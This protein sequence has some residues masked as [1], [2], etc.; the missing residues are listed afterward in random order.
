MCYTHGYA[1][2]RI[3]K[4]QRVIINAVKHSLFAHSLISA[5]EEGGTALPPA[6]LS[7]KFVLERLLLVV[8]CQVLLCMSISALQDC[9]TSTFNLLKKAALNLEKKPLF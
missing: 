9:I 5:N 4:S 3:A 8:L 1:C 7:W 6:L 2:A